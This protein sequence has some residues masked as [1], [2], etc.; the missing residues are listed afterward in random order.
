MS[1]STLAMLSS[2]PGGSVSGTA[3]TSSSVTE[4]PAAR[5]PIVHVTGP[6]PVHSGGRVTIVVPA[7]ID[8]VSTTPVASDGPP[9][10][11]VSV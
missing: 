11:T 2:G 10:T 5:S 7:G 8:S 6:V 9:L 1:P 4:P 3:S